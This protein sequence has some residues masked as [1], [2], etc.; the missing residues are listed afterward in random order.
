MVHTAGASSLRS[1]GVLRTSSTFPLP[2]A[3][4]S[5]RKGRMTTRALARQPAG[6]RPVRRVLGRRAAT[7]GCPDDEDRDPARPSLHPGG[8]PRAEAVIIADGL[9]RVTM[10]GQEVAAVGRG[11]VVGEMAVLDGGPRSATV[12]ALTPVAAYVC[13]PA[14][15]AA[16]CAAAP[17][18]DRIIRH[19]AAAR[20]RANRSRRRP[21]GADRS[22]RAARSDARRRHRP[23]APS[24]GH[25]AAGRAAGSRD[26]VRVRPARSLSPIRRRSS[27]CTA[28]V[29]PAP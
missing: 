26:H 9:A 29:R 2:F 27:C 28:S 16:L 15:L 24:P 22:D 23:P 25:V 20:A 3:S 19:R 4:E 17:S 12:T 5:D 18:V 21:A 11:D 6:A 7:R 14:E 1:R 13:T 8:A 10:G